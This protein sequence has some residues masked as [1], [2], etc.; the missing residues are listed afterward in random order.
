MAGARRMRH[1]AGRHIGLLRQRATRAGRF[2]FESECRGSFG[3][4]CALPLGR[5]L[6]RAHIRCRSHLA[7]VS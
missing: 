3:R 1:R 5:Y 6:L 2:Y 7:L 4:N